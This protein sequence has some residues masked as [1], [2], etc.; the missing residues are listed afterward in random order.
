MAVRYRKYFNQCKLIKCNGRTGKY[1]PGDR[2]TNVQNG[3]YRA[4]GAYVVE[5]FD[6]NRKWQSL[7]FK[8]VRSR[9]DAEKRLAVLIADRER[10]KLNLVTR[11]HIPT[12]AEYCLKYLELSRNDKEN[13]LLRKKRVVNTLTKYMGDYRLD[14]I[15]PFIIEKFRNERKTKDNIKNSSMNVDVITLN[16]IYSTA[17]REGLIEKN[18]C[19]DVKKLKIDQSKDRIL[20]IHEI[21]T[22]FENLN[23]KYRLMVMFGIFCGLR[24]GEV[25]SLKWED[26]N[27]EEKMLIVKQFK[28][29][30]I[31]TVPLAGFLLEELLKYK[32][33]CNSKTHLFDTRRINAAI[34][35]QYSKFFANKFIKFGIHGA[36]FHTLRH[37]Y[38]TYQSQTGTDLTTTSS[39][40]GHSSLA[41][42]SRYSHSQ[43][44]T[45]RKAV[46]SVSDFILD[47]IKKNG[48]EKVEKTA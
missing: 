19:S 33:T 1:C 12:L 44:E 40:L 32:I 9:A 3:S 26:I 13:N 2:P 18:P 34:G 15:T 36:T 30:K 42:T 35:S 29:G 22:L 27:F 46:D 11:K 37:S 17:I 31:V 24:L 39:L 10:G 25:I 41:M 28:T 48:A 14:K 8:D 47:S 5:L 23:N 21:S 6:E 43:L 4:C 16:H 7:V 20:S 38:A 45:K